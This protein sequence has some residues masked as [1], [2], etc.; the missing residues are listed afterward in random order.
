MKV[1]ILAGGF[2]TRI[3]EETGDKPKPMIPIGGF[4]ILWHI[5]KGYSAY[6]FREFIL[7]L[8]YKG[9][10]VKQYF[11]QYALHFSDVTFDFENGKQIVHQ[12]HHD[13]WKV[14]LVDTG[15]ST[16]TGGRIKRIQPYVGD[17]PFMMTY[18]DGVGN[19]ALDKLIR[20]HRSHGKKATVTAVRPPGRFGALT[21]D[22]EHR[23]K[24]FQEKPSASQWIN[25]GFFVLEPEVFSYIEGD[26]TVWERE[27]MERLAAEGELMAFKHSGFWHPM[28]TAKDKE[29]LESLW[30]S[31]RAPW[32][33]WNRT[34]AKS[35]GRKDGT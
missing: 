28:D 27:P 29:H 1:V 11:Q 17:E 32:K 5:M 19:A 23:V 7:C 2:G 35:E 13:P 21:I 15:L 18:G 14:T 20:F 33:L 4:P 22:P 8:G 31:G 30:Q 24:A 6:G 12:R 16:L 34:K 3:R 10:V 9:E 26:E 25:A